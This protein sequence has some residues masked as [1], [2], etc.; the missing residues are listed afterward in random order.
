MVELEAK[1]LDHLSHNLSLEWKWEA[2]TYPPLISDFDSAYMADTTSD[3]LTIKKM[4]E[5]KY[6]FSVKATTDGNRD[7]VRTKE[8]DI[9][10]PT[11]P[12]VFKQRSHP[13]TEHQKRAR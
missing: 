9:L 11:V 3:H 10:R 5:G 13:L 7:R 4:V 8:K 1:V 6:V 12:G 2:K